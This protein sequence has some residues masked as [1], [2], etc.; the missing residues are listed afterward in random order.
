MIGKIWKKKLFK[1]VICF[2]NLTT[3]SPI[4]ILMLG[5]FTWRRIDREK[6][7]LSLNIIA[8]TLELELDSAIWW[9]V[10]VK[11]S[12]KITFFDEFFVKSQKP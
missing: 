4:L 6:F 5:D 7:P 1:N 12:K 11:L 2:D 3:L 8:Q 10:P 9:A